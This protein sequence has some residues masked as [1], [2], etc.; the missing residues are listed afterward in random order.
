MEASAQWPVA[1]RDGANRFFENVLG[2]RQT[3]DENAKLMFSDDGSVDIEA[4][5]LDLSGQETLP[6]ERT[7]DIFVCAIKIIILSICGLVVKL[8]DFSGMRQRTSGLKTIGLEGAISLLLAQLQVF[9]SFVN[10]LSF[11]KLQTREST[12][13]IIGSGAFY[14]LTSNDDSV[15]ETSYLLKY[16]ESNGRIEDC[17]SIRQMAFYQKFDTR[18]NLSQSLLIQTSDQV[19]RRIFQLVQDGH[20][21]DFPNHW[22]TFHEVFLGTL[23]HNWGAYIEWIDTQISKVNFDYYFTKVDATEPTR[24]HFHNLQFLNKG[25]DVVTKMSQALQ[26]N[27]DA[28]SC[29]SEEAIHRSTIEGQRSAKRY[30]QF[31]ENIQMCIRE[32]SFFKKHVDLLHTFADRRSLQ[33]RD[34][35]ALQE[36]NIMMGMNQ[37]TTQETTTMRTITLIALVYLPASFTATFMGTGFVHV[38][39]LAGVMRIS[40][41]KDIYFYLAITIPLMAV[42]FLAWGLWELKMRKKARVGY[43]AKDDVEIMKNK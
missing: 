1:K 40:V 38:E 26:S 37:I 18:H 29:L 5:D 33:L 39:S 17:W 27:I 10:I 43:T 16:V 8:N 21:A 3:Y 34:A 4:C 20:M 23:S 9:P 42:T 35:I 25:I 22:T 30:Q 24:I 19:Q 36:S 15:Y 13:A 41:S 2:N 32:Q 7:T 11:F 28:M 14:G 6:L 12:T 31:Q